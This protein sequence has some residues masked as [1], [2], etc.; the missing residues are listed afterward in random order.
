M[1]CRRVLA[2]RRGGGGGG[3]PSCPQLLLLFVASEELG[4]IGATKVR[5]YRLGPVRSW[6]KTDF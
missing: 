4:I 2:L 3:I 6:V 1:G 5:S